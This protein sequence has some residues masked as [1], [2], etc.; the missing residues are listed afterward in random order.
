MIKRFTPTAVC[1]L[2][3]SLTIQAQELNNLLEEVKYRNIGPFRG[4]RSVAASGVAGDPLIA[5]MGTTGGG[6][7][8]T[9]DAGQH[10]SNISDDY[11]E[12]GSVGAIA[13]ASSNSNILYCGMGE[14][15]PRGVMT[16]YGDGVYKS[17]DAGKTW[18]HMGL[19]KTQHISRIIIHPKNPDIVFVAAQGALYGPNNERGIYK[20]TDGG[21]SWT[22]V[23]FVNNLTGCSELSMDLSN[24]QVIYAALWEHQRK[25]WKVIS[26]GAGSGLY[27]STDGGETWTKKENGLP[28]EKGKM[29]VSIC[30][31]N[32]DKVYALVE[33]DTQKEQSGLF[34]SNDGG[35]KWALV[36]GDHQLTQRA[37]YYIEVFAD[38]TNE[39]TVYVLSAPAL[40]SI[41]GGKTWQKLSGTHGDFHDLWIDPEN[42]KHLVIA[43]DGGAS[44]SFNSGQSWSTQQNM[45]TAQF[46][47]VATDNLFPYNIYGGQ[48]DNTS[49][50]IASQ[51]LGWSGIDEHH[52][53]ASAGG[54]SAFLA[55]DPDHPRFVMGGSYLGTI[56]LLDTKSGS[57]TNVMAAPIQY[58]GKEARDMKYLY[59]WN[60][61]IVKSQYEP[62]TYF[63]GAQI[64]LKTQDN[65]LSWQEISPD[66]TRNDDSKQGKGGGPYT[67]EAVGAENYG[68]L[69]YVVESPHEHGVIWT[70]SD[71]GYVQ[72]TKNGGTSWANVTPKKLQECLINTIDVSSH[73]PAS[74]Y[75]AT[76]RYKFNDHSPG[77]YKTKDY[78]KT[79]TNISNGIPNGAYTRVVREDPVIKGLLYA[80]TE[81][82]IYVSW[83]DGSTWQSLQLNMPV[84]PI[85]D[86]TVKGNDLVVATSGRS[87]WI[88]DD[89]GLI[90]QWKNQEKNKLFKPSNAIIGEW[91]SSLNSSGPEVKG[92]DATAGVNPANG[93]TIYYHLADTADVMLT[94]KDE[95]GNVLRK[96]SSIGDDSF[97]SY[98]GGPSAAPTLSAEKGLNRFV[99]D[100]HVATMK[101]APTAYI[102]GG[103]QG[104]KVPPSNYNLVL[105]AGSFKDS[106]ECTIEPNPLYKVTAEEYASYHSYMIEMEATFNDMHEKVNTIMTM[107]NQLDEV[108]V[109]LTNDT[110]KM[111]I[112]I[113][114]DLLRKRM[115]D[116]D[117]LMIQRKAKAYDDVENYE[118]KFTAEYLFLI[119]QT[120]GP[121]AKITSSSKTRRKE[122]EEQWKKLN[123][124]A[125]SIIEEE[126]PAFNQILWEAGI[127]AV[128]VK[129]K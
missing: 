9:S 75:I 3:I 48:Q 47:R 4:G 40:K 123:E 100:M 126:I 72:L 58:L 89:L 35:E 118:N 57:T 41:D 62:N 63:H 85:N 10:W 19:S 122:L 124:T 117:D 7:W 6:L 120:Y 114:G 31:S 68:T 29:A 8:K 70:G 97:L 121:Q 116:W 83:D 15:A 129:K 30:Q 87:F 64:L 102:E 108:L 111:E 59:N 103:Y 1:C 18:Q 94:I 127:G 125:V 90:R 104:H 24:P 106:V 22:Q 17:Y 32:P 128:R 73:H 14:H 77:L 12:T 25:P 101:G 52:W 110:S 21:K 28:K 82:G 88:L 50:K 11:F 39:N 46:Y 53:S 43:N 42:S 86:L 5:Y 33:S 113:K 34:A 98:P 105:S 37:W 55:F 74:A 38:P 67:N 36:S 79:W 51:T 13:V 115:K 81:L 61:P 54:E 56:G 95:K 80:G 60:A 23:L 44:I 91:Y 107:R 99:W 66:L 78:G 93:V 16:S 45:P 112:K 109:F 20:S 26:G 49:I 71:D 76:T 65:G 69:S 27:K 96:F 119:N 2:L 92:T 84:V